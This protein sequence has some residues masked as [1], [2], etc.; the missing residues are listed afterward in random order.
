MAHFLPLAWMYREDY[1]QGGF[2]MLPAV[3][4]SGRST[5]RQTLFFTVLLAGLSLWPVALSLVGCPTSSAP[6]PSRSGS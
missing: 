5:V 3:D 4:P 6:P 1:G 2:V